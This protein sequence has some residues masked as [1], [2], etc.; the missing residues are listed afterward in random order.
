MGPRLLD[1][2]EHALLLELQLLDTC[3]NHDCLLPRLVLSVLLV[4]YRALSSVLLFAFE[5]G[6][7]R[8][9]SIRRLQLLWRVYITACSSFVGLGA[10]GRLRCRPVEG[11][12]KKDALGTCILE[13]AQILGRFETVHLIFC[14]FNVSFRD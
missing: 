6:N 7:I 13:L 12:L 2:L 4:Q 1:L 10:R 11:I 8:R 14:H 5:K 9:L 3:L